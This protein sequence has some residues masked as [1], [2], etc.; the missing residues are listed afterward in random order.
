MKLKKK[1]AVVMLTAVAL[2]SMPL[3]ASDY[4]N[5]WAKPAIDKWV[6]RGIIGGFEDG[7][8]RPSE[9]ITKAQFAKILV[10][11]FGYGQPTTPQQFTDVPNGKWYSDVVNRISDEKIMYIEG[12]TFNPNKAIT[13]EEAAYALKNAYNIASVTETTKTFKDSAKVS[14][15]AKEA[16]N[17]MTE[18][19]LIA[20]MPD[21]SFNPQ[22]SLTRAEVVVMLE[23]LTG[24]IISKPGTYT[25]DIKGNVIVNTGDVILKDM[26]IT[27]NLILTEGIGKGE[28]TLENVTVTGD[29]IVAEG[30]T[31]KGDD[32]TIIDPALPGGAAPGTE[33]TPDTTTP[34]TTT[35]PSTGGSSSSE[36]VNNRP[37]YVRPGSGSTTTPDP[38]SPVIPE[39][40]DIDPETGKVTTVVPS[41]IENGTSAP[42]PIHVP[43]S[44][45]VP[46]ALDNPTAETV[47]A[48]KE[49][50]IQLDDF[51]GQT[52]MTTPFRE[53][54][55]ES[56]EEGKFNI[57]IVKDIIYDPENSDQVN[58]ALLKKVDDGTGKVDMQKAKELYL[59]NY[60]KYQNEFE[61][62]TA[63]E[64]GVTF[65]VTITDASKSVATTM[66]I[67]F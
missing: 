34:G 12:T 32:I 56:D 28:V 25:K 48:V 19:G 63:T 58:E 67:H 18:N 50:E 27:G 47:V 9:A 4:N 10:S 39:I 46:P 16:V 17:A 41:I 31:V 66:T 5:H 52:T 35:T 30:I 64:E 21:G 6:N 20:G 44:T 15:W 59:R 8:F 23:R 57:D 53:Q 42:A 62:I 29:K 11:I 7:T 55:F 22:G 36:S 61:G 2:T 60:A 26:T 38:V 43:L 65:N 40:P 33:T 1:L 37:P 49:V 24:E 54:P 51:S 13:R 3:I 14:A 45:I